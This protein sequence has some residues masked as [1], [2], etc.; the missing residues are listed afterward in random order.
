MQGPGKGRNM[1]LG[2]QGGRKEE[3][4]GPQGWWPVIE[5]KLLGG[6]VFGGCAMRLGEHLAQCLVC[7]M[8]S[9]H[10]YGSSGLPFWLVYSAPGIVPGTSHACC[11]SF[12]KPERKVL[13]FP[14]L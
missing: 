9:L 8:L 14:I 10:G 3:A 7:P 13:L 4:E 5:Y 11:L 6:L 12:D 2:F 1:G